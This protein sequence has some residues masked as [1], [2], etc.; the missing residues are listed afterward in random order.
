MIGLFGD[1]FG[2][3][4]DYARDMHNLVLKEIEEIVGDRKVVHM[5]HFDHAGLRPLPGL[6]EFHKLFVNNRGP[7]NHYNE[8]AN[9][10]IFNAVY[11][12]I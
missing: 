12:K 7:V 10:L 2:Y 11:D 3:N 1:S 6:L 9:Q 5:T 8:Q 4:D